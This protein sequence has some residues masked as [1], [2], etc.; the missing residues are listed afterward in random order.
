MSYMEA[1]AKS[2]KSPSGPQ[3][4]NNCLKIIFMMTC[5]HSHDLH[6]SF[7]SHWKKMNKIE[8]RLS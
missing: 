6:I 1:V 2:L 3:F 5:F 8:K 7:A 4:E